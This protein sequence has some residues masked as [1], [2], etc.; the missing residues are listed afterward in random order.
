MTEEK[1]TTRFARRTIEVKGLV[2]Y[3]ELPPDAI[4]KMSE[5]GVH[6]SLTGG[7]LLEPQVLKTT[8]LH[9]GEGIEVPTSLTSSEQN[10]VK[11]LA[12]QYEIGWVESVEETLIHPSAPYIEAPILLHNQTDDT[13]VKQ[14]IVGCETSCTVTITLSRCASK[15]LILLEGTDKNSVS[16]TEVD[17]WVQEK[18]KLIRDSLAHAGF[19]EKDIEIDCEIIMGAEREAKCDPDF[20]RSLI[21]DSQEE[22]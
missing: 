13:W 2:Q 17:L 14:W 20:M 8:K 9:I 5:Y 6:W 7:V 11:D 18:I 4:Q 12:E 22:E 16:N 10:W 21:A 3:E 15:L 1:E 19:T